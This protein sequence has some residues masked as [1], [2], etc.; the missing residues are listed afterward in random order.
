[1][2]PT[3]SAYAFVAT[4]CGSVGLDTLIIL[5]LFVSIFPP[6]DIVSTTLSDFTV[7]MFTTFKTLIVP[8]AEL[9]V[10]VVKPVDFI[11][12][13]TSSFSVGEVTPIPILL[14]VCEFVPDV[15]HDPAPITIA[16]TYFFVATWWS[17]VGSATL[18]ILL[19]FTSIVP[20]TDKE[21]VTSSV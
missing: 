11:V 21:S 9:I 13:S 3:E 15:A 6:T 19:S 17:T 8:L 16:S 14:V 7:A 10:V 4:S 12:P 1:M 5:L 20:L 2:P 18:I